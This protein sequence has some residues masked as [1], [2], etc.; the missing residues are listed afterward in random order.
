M[1]CMWYHCMQ[2]ESVGILLAVFPIA[3]FVFLSRRSL[4][5]KNEFGRSR[6]AMEYR[7]KINYYLLSSH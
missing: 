1:S 3:L 6:H 7:K 2:V 5:T 4:G